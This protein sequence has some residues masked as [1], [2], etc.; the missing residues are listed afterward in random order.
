MSGTGTYSSFYEDYNAIIDRYVALG[1]PR[2]RALIAAVGG[3]DTFGDIEL[4]LLATL[5]LRDGHYLIDVGCGS[6]RLTRRA[7][8][9]AGLRY[10]GTDVVQEM[11]DHASRTCGRPD[12]R[13]QHVTGL[14]IPEADG[15]ADFVSFFSV[16]T[17]LRHEEFFL[18]LSDARRVLKPG[19]RIVFSFLDIETTV[20]REVF[21]IG[22]RQV[23]HNVSGWHLNQFIGRSEIPV[24]ARFLGM[25]KVCMIDGDAPVLTAPPEI[26]AMLSKPVAGAAFGQSVCVLEKKPL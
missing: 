15:V 2:E 9:M 3:D 19:G 11:L 7:A 10:L 25:R 1:M 23:R 17:H 13:F 21:E 8:R 12:F 16:G 14:S 20:G 22:L 18:Y 26:A 24:W 6:G 4:T 5:G